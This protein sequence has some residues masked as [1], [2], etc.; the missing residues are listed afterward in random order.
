MI[1][2][3]PPHQPTIADLLATA[4]RPLFSF[5]FFPPRSP[6]GEETLWRAIRELESIRPDFVSVTYGAN[7]S[8]RERTIRATER[9]A[10]GTNLRTMG[11][12]TCVSQSR[13][14]LRRT[15]GAYASVGLQH[16]LAIRGDPPGGPTAPWQAHPEGL[17]NATELVEMIASLGDFCIGVAA[18]PDVHPEQRDPD[19]DARLLVAKARAGAKFAITQF[20]FDPQSYVDLVA[21]VRALDCDIPIIPGIQPVTSVKQIERFAELSGAALPADLVAKLHAVQD[22]PEQVTE[23]GIA[24]AVDLCRDL[25]AAGAPGLH[26]YTQNRSLATRRIHQQLIDELG[27]DTSVPAAASEAA[28]PVRRLGSA[29][30]R[31]ERH[32]PPVVPARPGVAAVAHGA[33]P[34]ERPLTLTDIWPPYGLRVTAGDLELRPVRE[35]D[36]PELLGLVAEGVHPRD[37]MPFSFPWTQAP[38]AELPAN[39][40]QWIA[41][42]VTET[43]RSRLNLQLVVRLGGRVVGVQGLGGADV[44]TLRTA[45]T[46]SWLGQRF[47]GQGI[48][49]RMRQAVCELAF[50]HLGLTEVTSGAFV[51]NPASLSV[52]RKVGYADNGTERF[53]RADGPTL[54]RKLVLTPD[55]LVRGEPITVEGADAL[56]A[57]HGLD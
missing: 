37:R 24:T 18:F 32:E 54:Q 39:Y 5:E 1:T 56:R 44:D 21:R 4:T 55:A 26:Y 40:L 13:A 22:D 51:D 9:I 29:V 23:V 12:L 52:S 31:P 17:R 47:H 20:F 28:L 34:L 25:L 15:I 57:F 46:G 2:K 6:E 36:A 42:T 38:A 14:D 43:S 16:I 30:A 50:D 33:G 53:N 48:G 35:S 45:E 41:R 27:I 8:T 49:T 11:H 10:T 3:Q 7:G 19:L